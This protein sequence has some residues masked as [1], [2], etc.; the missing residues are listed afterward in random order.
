[1]SAHSFTI[2]KSLLINYYSQDSHKDQEFPVWN[3]LILVTIYFPLFLISLAQ[4]LKIPIITILSLAIS[5]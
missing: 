1:M 4:A 3:S 5:L 2:G